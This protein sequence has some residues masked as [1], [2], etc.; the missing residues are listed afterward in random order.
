MS[1]WLVWKIPR[2]WMAA[3]VLVAVFAAV[4]IWLAPRAQPAVFVR[5]IKFLA[6][7]STGSTPVRIE[8]P[9]SQP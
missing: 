3:L 6:T 5:A 1:R 7:R 2:R 8:A 4:L 9:V